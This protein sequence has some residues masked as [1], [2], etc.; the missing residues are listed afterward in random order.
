MG[1]YPPQQFEGVP[2]YLQSHSCS[3]IPDQDPIQ[4]GH[5]VAHDNTVEYGGFRTVLWDAPKDLRTAV[6]D[7]VVLLTYLQRRHRDLSQ[8]ATAQ[9]LVF[10][11]R[12]AVHNQ[13]L[14]HGFQTAWLGRLR[15]TTTAGATAHIAVIVQTGCGFLSGGRRGVS[16]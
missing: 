10:C 7:I 5:F 13:L 8:G 3:P 15:I 12:T 6:E 2:A 16:R 4:I 9:L 14:Q 11:N 1:H